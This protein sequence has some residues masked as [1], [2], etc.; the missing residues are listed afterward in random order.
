VLGLILGIVL[1]AGGSIP[2][3]GP[4][5]VLVLGAAARGA[6]REALSTAIGGAAG[7]T[8]WCALA[9]LGVAT[10]LQSMPGVLVVARGAAALLL[11]AAGVF[12]LATAGRERPGRARSGRAESD[13]RRG[14]V[15][16]L[17]LSLLNPALLASWGAAA[18]T[19]HGLGLVGTSSCSASLVPLGLPLGIVWWC[20]IAVLLVARIG[21][22]I[23]PRTRVRLA[24]SFG[25]ALVAVAIGAFVFACV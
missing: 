18:A 2:M 17:S 25:A 8:F 3:A 24:R 22:R 7:E 14:L 4:V 6:R 15:R 1:G 11:L 5:G 13:A 19:L 9:F 21:P 12:V 20:A 10:F 23:A 16:G